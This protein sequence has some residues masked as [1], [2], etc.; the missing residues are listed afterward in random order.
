MTELISGRIISFLKDRNVIQQDEE[1]Y[2]YG[3]DAVVYTILSTAGLVLIST[4]FGM[5]LEGCICIT[6]FYLNQS[7]GGGY[8]A[9]THL[10]CFL[11]MSLGLML[12][13]GIIRS[14]TNIAVLAIACIPAFIVLFRFPLVLHPFLRHLGKKGD[15]LKLRSYIL[16]ASEFIFC[17]ACFLHVLSGISAS[18]F[19]AVFFSAASRTAGFFIYKL[20]S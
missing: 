9:N 6:I 13:F 20:Q 7:I 15:R 2:L 5:L 17:L 8:H 3:C 12:S 19:T 16:S 10:K 18:I 1:V 11:V 4:I 14:V